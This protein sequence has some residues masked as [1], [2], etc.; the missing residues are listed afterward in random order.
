MRPHS[1]AFFL[2]CAIG[3]LPS[4][5]RSEIRTGVE[6][7]T[8]DSEIEACTEAEDKAHS[9]IN[10]PTVTVPFEVTNA[11]VEKCE[12]G[13]E[14]DSRWKCSVEWGADLKKK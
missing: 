7:G 3:C 11:K 6:V 1:I 10:S 4:N 2:V 5:A 8:G 9:R 14:S 13:K 12:C